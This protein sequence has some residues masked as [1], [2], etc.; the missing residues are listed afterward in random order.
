MSEFNDSSGAATYGPVG[1]HPALLADTLSG[2][3]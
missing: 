3:L 1:E 2:G